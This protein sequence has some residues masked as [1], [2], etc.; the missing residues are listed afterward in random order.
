[1]ST[2]FYERESPTAS[3]VPIFF[4][5]LILLATGGLGLFWAFTNTGISWPLLGLGAFVIVSALTMLSGIF[6]LNPNECALFLFFGDYVGSN[7]SA[8]LR[9]THPFY[10]VI[11]ANLR[12]QTLITPTLKVNDQRGN[13]IEVAAMAIWHVEDAAAAMFGLENVSSFL[14]TA[15]ESTL[16]EIASRHPY[17]HADDENPEE[18][19]LRGHVSAISDN[20][21]TLLRERMGETSGAIAITDCK[22]THL[23]YAPEIASSMLRRQQA[24]AVVSARKKIVLGAVGMV[25]DALQ[26]LEGRG[27]KIDDDRKA[28]MVGNLLVVLCGDRE[29]QPVINTGSSYNP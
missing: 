27:I 17:D 16:R 13:P 21:K 7:R 22:L 4:I 10:T 15:M 25:D 12:T 6:T 23:A 11:K 18:I 1:M 14:T 29:A 2:S 28:A 20:L 5:S 8:G 19:T 26:G 24:E 9:W 3:G